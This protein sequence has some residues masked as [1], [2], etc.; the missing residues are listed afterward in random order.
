MFQ[1]SSLNLNPFLLI[2]IIIIYYSQYLYDETGMGIQ[3]APLMRDVTYYHFQSHNGF[4]FLMDLIS[5]IKFI[6]NV[7]L[8]KGSFT[9]APV[10]TFL[11]FPCA[12][13][14]EPV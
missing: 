1:L 9:L 4:L 8:R 7:L 10:N 5:M 3:I 11:S 14:D 13:L 12:R 2:E 6:R